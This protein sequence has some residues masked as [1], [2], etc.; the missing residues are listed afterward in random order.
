M[1]IFDLVTISLL[2]SDQY[3]HLLHLF[4]PAGTITITSQTTSCQPPPSRMSTAGLRYVIAVPCGG[5]KTTTCSDPYYLDVDSLY[6][7]RESQTTYDRMNTRLKDLAQTH[8]QL[9]SKVLAEHRSRIKN[10]EGRAQCLLVHS[11]DV[12]KLG[13]LQ[14]K[15]VLVPSAR[16][17]EESISGRAELSK[18]IARKN[19][20]GL[21]EQCARLGQAYEEYGSWTKLECLLQDLRDE[22]DEG[23]FLGGM[24]RKDSAVSRPEGDGKA[25]ESGR[26]GEDE[27]ALLFLVASGLGC[28]FEEEG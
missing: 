3:S 5:G 12:A 6:T 28:R 22:D 7:L 10:Y 13:G 17:H 21:M 18:W 25:G 19:R 24:A 11:L 16:L 20:T 27:E 26:V 2:E 1:P 9:P 23:L 15:A 14:L 8:S 4:L